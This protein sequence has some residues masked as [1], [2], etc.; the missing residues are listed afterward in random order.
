V[1]LVLFEGHRQLLAAALLA[2]RF[3][4]RVPVPHHPEDGEGH[5]DDDLEAEAFV[6]E[7]EEAE[8]ED[9]HGLHVAQDLEGHGGEA[10]DADELAQVDPD[11]DEA[12]QREEQL[13]QKTVR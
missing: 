5:P 9:E 13:R 8:G 7:E 6:A 3:S 11:G 2:A 10:A 4:G 1:I 12:R